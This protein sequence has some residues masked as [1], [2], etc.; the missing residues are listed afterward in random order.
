MVFGIHNQFQNDDGIVSILSLG[1]KGNNTL[2]ELDL[3]YLTSEYNNKLLLL[4]GGQSFP[5]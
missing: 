5:S 1:L 2:R 4:D 3:G